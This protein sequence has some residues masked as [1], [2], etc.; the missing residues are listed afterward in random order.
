MQ[1][2]PEAPPPSDLCV[3]IERTYMLRLRAALDRAPRASHRDIPSGAAA[4]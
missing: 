2:T 1:A 3:G 4:R